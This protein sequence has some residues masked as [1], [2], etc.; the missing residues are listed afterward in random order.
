MPRST[1][2]RE[3]RAT[4]GRDRR[5][6]V[7]CGAPEPPA[8]PCAARRPPRGSRSC[9][10]RARHRARPGDRIESQAEARRDTRA[11]DRAPVCDASDRNRDDDRDHRAL[12]D[13]DANVEG[14]IVDHRAGWLDPI[15]VGLTYAGSWAGL[16]LVLGLATAVALR[17]PWLLAA[18][19]GAVLAADL[20]ARGLKMAVDRP[21]PAN[22]LGDIDVLTSTPSGSSFPSGH[23]ATSFAAATV[24]SL[25]VPRLAPL[26]LG[27]AAA[28]AYSR[29]YVGVHYPLDVL[30]GAAL[31]V[32]VATALLLL[33]GSLR[34]AR[35]PPRRAP[36]TGPRPGCSSPRAGPESR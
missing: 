30:A 14:W 9:N 25:A 13:V 8:T 34:R 3:G 11:D 5:R 19:A 20:S 27:L 21:R 12:I 32:F 1:S 33:A 36:P 18:V 17:R 7:A 24:L 28:V 16:W 4:T 22:R 31:G 15:F 10:L 35:R 26:F 29:L 6:Q 23:A 2:T